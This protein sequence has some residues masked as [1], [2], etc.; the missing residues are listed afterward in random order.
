[1]P[2]QT[3]TARRIATVAL[4]TVPVR[5]SVYK[6][7]ADETANLV[8]N[9]GAEARV[10]ADTAAKDLNLTYVLKEFPDCG[11]AI[12]DYCYLSDEQT[13]ALREGPFREDAVPCWPT[14]TD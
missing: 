7:A 4:S 13:T 14:V 10:P 1:M 6:A 9:P 5:L 8:E 2:Y 3:V 11:V 12:F